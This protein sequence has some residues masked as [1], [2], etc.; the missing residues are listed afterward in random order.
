MKLRN[1]ACSIPVLCLALTGCGKAP[2][3]GGPPSEFEVPAVVA[4]VEPQEILERVRLIGTM[5]S[6]ATVDIASELSGVIEELLFTEGQFVEEGQLLARIRDDSVRARLREARARFDLAAANYARGQDLLEAQTIAQ[7]DFDRLIAEYGIAE[8]VVAS[9]EA[10]LADTVIKAP[11]DGVISERLL[12]AGQFVTTGQRITTMVQQDPLEAEFRVPERY[13]AQLQIGQ[14]IQLQSTAWGDRNFDGRIFFI[15]P[16]V[17]DRSRTILVKAE[18]ANTDGVLKPGMLV[19][20]D[21][22]ISER[23]Q[24]LIVPEAAVHYRGGAPRV[25]IMDADDR[26]AI[27]FVE[28]GVRQRG[29]IEITSG[30]EPQDRVVV[31]GHQKLGPGTKIVIA[32][33]SA[34]YG[35]SPTSLD[36]V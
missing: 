14:M 15:S 30:L 25:V 19:H 31:E 3:A 29:Q 9:A 28:L 4:L 33:G 35:L 22:I 11:F 27:R 20:L 2:G 1:V 13:I 12:S 17:D 7:S 32:P 21:W 23:D 26:A 18:V 8:A 36:G 16:R 6:P 10:A 24:A 34:Q 5:R